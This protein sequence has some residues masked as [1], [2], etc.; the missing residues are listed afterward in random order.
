MDR[1]I[2]DL[3]FGVLADDFDADG[4]RQADK[5]TEQPTRSSVA[6]SPTV[7]EAVMVESSNESDDM[8]ESISSSDD[9]GA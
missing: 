9:D 4:P 5:T 7:R 3:A 8:I 1:L 6:N 2:R